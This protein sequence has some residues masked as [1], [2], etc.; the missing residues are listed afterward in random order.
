MSKISI[1]ILIVI[2]V[3]LSGCGYGQPAIP[4]KD[5]Q[6]KGVYKIYYP[7]YFMYDAKMLNALL[8]VWCKDEVCRQN[9]KNKPAKVIYVH[10]LSGNKCKMLY[11]TAKDDEAAEILKLEQQKEKN[12]SF[13]DDAFDL[14]GWHYKPNT[15]LIWFVRNKN[16]DFINSEFL[17]LQDKKVVD[18]KLIENTQVTMLYDKNGNKLLNKTYENIYFYP[19][20]CN[21]ILA[22]DGFKYEILPIATRG[23]YAD[24]ITPEMEKLRQT[25]FYLDNKNSSNIKIFAPFGYMME[26]G[27]NFINRKKIKV[28]HLFDK[29]GGELFDG[30]DL[31]GVVKVSDHRLIVYAIKPYTDNLE[32]F[33]YDFDNKKVLFKVDWIM[34]D[35]ELGMTNYD[36]LIFF[37]DK[38]TGI[39][40]FDG[41][42][43]IDLQ[44][45]YV[46]ENT[47][48][49]F[50]TYVD[51]KGMYRRGLLDT[52][53][54]HVMKDLSK[55]DFRDDVFIAYAKDRIVVFDYSKN[56]LQDLKANNITVYDDFYIASFKDED[57]LYGKK[58]NKLFDKPYKDLRL[59]DNGTISYTLNRKTAVMDIN[60][61][62]IIPPIC[63]S[64]KL[65][66]CGVIEC[67][68]NRND[69]QKLLRD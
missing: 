67:H 5:E 65:G 59:L 45:K 31:I 43:V 64:V 23:K 9:Y 27:E 52:K 50:I 60:A 1:A 17:T 26:Y 10:M 11:S 39:A 35:Y 54:N 62:E 2:A 56:I 49:G 16:G 46:F 6:T 20:T 44:S 69:L 18:R 12:C 55:V 28:Y 24:F 47:Y 58:W 61:K 51:G 29:D 42:V 41:N 63:S 13:I 32:A 22:V 57:T 19:Q 3:L 34:P 53:L 68:M 36:K 38:K 30:A 40:D 25:K 15:V 37:K 21:K 7:N 48:K 8:D 14:N 4:V 66:Q 33:L